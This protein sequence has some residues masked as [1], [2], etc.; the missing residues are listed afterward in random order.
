MA[1]GWWVA[2]TVTPSPF[3]FTLTMGTPV[4]EKTEDV[5]VTP[6]GFDLTL[7]WGTPVNGLSVSP[8]P[9]DLTLD[10]G[11]PVVIR[12]EVATPAGMNLTLAGGTPEVIST[13]HQFPTPAGVN[14]GLTWGTPVV[15]IVPPTAYDAVGPGESGFGSV[16]DFSFTAAAGADVFVV[17]ANDRS[18]AHSGGATYGGVAMTQVA[19]AIHNNTSANG[20]VAVYRLAGA[21]TGGAQTVSVANGSGWM[22]ANAISFTEV[23]ATITTA[24]NT[25][26]GTLASQTVSLTSP[27][28]LQILSGGNGGGTTTTFG[29]FTGVTNRYNKKSTGSL[30]AINTVTASGTVSASTNN[31]WAAVFINL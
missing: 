15:T 25:G 3:A 14:L 5:N 7:G 9:L 21:G 10:W 16:S 19:S 4:I 12:D 8:A 22:I 18:A 13:A 1:T 17:V 29:S 27:V 6:A 2:N 23:H 20:G 11:T 28:G 30:L 31:P 26:T 24:T